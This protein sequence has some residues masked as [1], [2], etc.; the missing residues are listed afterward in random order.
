M[1][2]LTEPRSEI[3][4]GG[5][6]VG[7]WHCKAESFCFEFAGLRRIVGAGNSSG[8]RRSVKLAAVF[9]KFA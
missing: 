9:D 6:D 2:R 7:R 3:F 1:L 8:W 5:D 4:A